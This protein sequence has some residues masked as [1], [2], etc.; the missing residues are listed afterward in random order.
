MNGHLLREQRFAP[1]MLSLISSE[2]GL[3]IC[4]GSAWVK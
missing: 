1:E 4:L 2:A 3:H